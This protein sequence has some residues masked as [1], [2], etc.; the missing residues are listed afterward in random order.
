MTASPL[1]VHSVSE[2]WELI[3]RIL[4]LL[5][6]V[7]PPAICE[8]GIEAGATSDRLLEWVLAHGGHLWRIDPEPPAFIERNAAEVATVVRGRSPNAL[9]HVDPPVDV[10]IVDGDHNYWTVSEELRVI[11]DRHLDRLDDGGVLLLHD[12]GWPAGRRDQYCDPSALPADAVH[13]HSWKLGVR[14]GSPGLVTSGFRGDGAF[15]IAL[16]EGGPRNGVLTAVEDFLERHSETYEYARVPLFFGLGVIWTKRH[17]QCDAIRDA[18]APFSTSALLE[19]A[20]A[21]RLAL[22][23]AVLERDCELRAQFVMAESSR[24]RSEDERAQLR[25]ASKESR[26]RA[27]V[28]RRELHSL[29]ASR[30]IRLLNLLERPA[31]RLRPGLGSVLER[32]TRLADIIDQAAPPD[33][34]VPPAASDPDPASWS[35]ART[36]TSIDTVAYGVAPLTADSSAP[37]PSESRQP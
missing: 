22:Y 10:W 33:H 37:T 18:C 32:I 4:L 24:S 25:T 6:S 8:I 12:V 21:N 5:E 11:H 15:A 1:L 28:I 36:G 23:L 16:S 13:P 3:D 17:P 20:E 7:S 9:S 2:Y 27:D 29:L 30:W 19:R 31:R 34:V 35:T 26:T 14:L